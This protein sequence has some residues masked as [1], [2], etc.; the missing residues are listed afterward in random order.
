M[1]IRFTDQIIGG[2]D[3]TEKRLPFGRHFLKELRVRIPIVPLAIDRIV[4]TENSEPVVLRVRPRVCAMRQR[5]R[6]KEE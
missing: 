6:E 2:A 4:T 1:A 3:R 5:L